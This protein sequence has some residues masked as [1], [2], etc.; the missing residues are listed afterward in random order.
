MRLSALSD[1]V[2]LTIE[3][4]VAGDRLK[5]LSEQFLLRTREELA[6]LRAQLAAARSGDAAA[7]AEMLRFAHRINGSG[8]MLGFNAISGCA[9][10]VEVI[11]RR[12]ESVLSEAE[13]QVILAQLQQMDVELAKPLPP[14]DK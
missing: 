10:Q 13:W 2:E 8:A 14:D 4:A 11:L 3:T 1:A 12:A 7:L 6:L 9:R 5:Q